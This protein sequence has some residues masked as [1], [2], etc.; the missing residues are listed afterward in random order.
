MTCVDETG[1]RTMGVTLEPGEGKSS[2]DP[3]RAAPS[4]QE[5][6]PDKPEKGKKP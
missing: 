3:D 5:H 6:K 1:N 2:H 4:I